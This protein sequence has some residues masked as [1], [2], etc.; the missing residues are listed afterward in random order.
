M[1]IASR[2]YICSAALPPTS[3]FQFL[4]RDDKSKFNGY[5]HRASS[6]QLTADQEFGIA[7]CTVGTFM[8]VIG[9]FVVALKWKAKREMSEEMREEL[10]A[11]R[12]RIL[13]PHELVSVVPSVHA[14]RLGV[15]EHP[16]VR[17][18]F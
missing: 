16:A 15:H 2:S 11:Q 3:S 13:S 10:T 1:R 5:S 8:L 14:N 6:V 9:Y 12:E 18:V 4:D 17:D 7:S